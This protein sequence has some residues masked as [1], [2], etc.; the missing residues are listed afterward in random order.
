MHEDDRIRKIE[1]TKRRI[2]YLGR[3]LGAQVNNSTSLRGDLYYAA[4]MFQQFHSECRELEQ[5][6]H[7]K[8]FEPK[9]VLR[10]KRQS[11]QS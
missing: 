9:I 7:K 6:K 2:K 8:P 4:P 11:K 1:E 5:L 10:K 3:Q